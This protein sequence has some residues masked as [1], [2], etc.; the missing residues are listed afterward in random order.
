MLLVDHMLVTSGNNV[1]NLAKQHKIELKST[2][3]QGEHFA[4]TLDTACKGL[5]IFLS[6]VIKIKGK[7]FVSL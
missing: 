6:S 1:V 3:H 4:R 5:N 7:H 2:H